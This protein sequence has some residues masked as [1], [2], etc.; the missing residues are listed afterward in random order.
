MDNVINSLETE[1]I[2]N[3]STTAIK[4][5]EQVGLDNMKA[6]KKDSTFDYK[7][8]AKKVK[9]MY[10]KL[11]SAEQKELYLSF[12]KYCSFDDLSRLRDFLGLS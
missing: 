10:D 7:T 8:A 3:A 6:Y 12:L 2:P 11:S 9:A 5:I 1:I 4:E